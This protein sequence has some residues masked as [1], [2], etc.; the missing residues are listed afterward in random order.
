MAPAKALAA[1]AL[2]KRLLVA[3]SEARR[4]VL[5]SE[6]TRISRPLRWID[7]AH[8]K[9]RPRLVAGLPMAA[10]LLARRS[11]G[12]TRWAAAGMGAARLYQSLRQYLQHRRSKEPD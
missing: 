5:A 4:L 3:E 7:A 11:R 8:L 2:Q 12:L 9:I 1:L 10:Y 6:L